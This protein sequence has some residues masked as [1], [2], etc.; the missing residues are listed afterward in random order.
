[1]SFPAVP[2][3]DQQYIQEASSGTGL[4]YNVVEAQAY[5]ESGYQSGVSSS[6]GAEGFWQFEPS[7][8]NAYAGAAGV[9]PGTEFNVADETQVYVK[10]MKALLSTYG[11]NVAD[12]LAAYNAGN[13][14]SPAGQQYASHILSLA[15]ANP[16]AVT[17]SSSVSTL[18]AIDPFPFGNFDPLNWPFSIGNAA[19]NAITNSIDSAAKKLGA[20]LWA[21]LK[22]LTIRLGLIVFGA[23]IVIVGINGFLKESQGPT[24]LVV[25]GA[26]S[27][28]KRVRPT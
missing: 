15:G 16:S 11:G 18:S 1:M 3:T 23:F 21:K 5:T 19:A 27:G 25:N 6:A 8:Y 9:A 2:A 24:Q 7:T 12:A 14:N 22:P 20:D 26:Q 13:A 17:T 10:Y 28:A 4:P